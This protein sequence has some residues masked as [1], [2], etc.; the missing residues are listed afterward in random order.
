[1]VAIVGPEHPIG[2]ALHDAIAEMLEALHGARRRR[3][4]ERRTEALVGAL[5]Q[6]EAG[7]NLG[8]EGLGPARATVR[9]S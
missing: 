3:R 6:V 5:M 9:P 1:M 4:P 7:Q 8:I 2:A